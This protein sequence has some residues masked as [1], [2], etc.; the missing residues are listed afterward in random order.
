ML[1]K[2]GFTK[3]MPHDWKVLKDNPF[4]RYMLAALIDQKQKYPYTVR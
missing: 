1:K 2:N 4:A 3:N